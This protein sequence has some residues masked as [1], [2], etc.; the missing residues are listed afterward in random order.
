MTERTLKEMRAFGKV[1]K[2]WPVERH[3]HFLVRH[4]TANCPGEL[5]VPLLCCCVTNMT[6][7]NCVGVGSQRGLLPVE[8][9]SQG[10]G[11]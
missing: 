1:G 10:S 11:V 5:Y 3:I 7:L 4:L 9:S 8:E 2:M 6:P